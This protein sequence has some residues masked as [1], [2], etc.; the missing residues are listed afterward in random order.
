MT[1]LAAKSPAK[2]PSP[3]HRDR[4]WI[5]P[6]FG[7]LLGAV[8]WLEC[9]ALGVPRIP[10]EKPGYHLIPV[11]VVVGAILGR[12][13]AQ[14]F[15]LWAAAALAVVLALIA[16]TPVMRRPARALVRSDRI[17]ARPVQAVVVL[18]GGI[19]TDGHLRS[20]SLDRALSGISLIRRGVA[21]TLIVSR[22]HLGPPGRAVTSDA[23]HQ[24][25]VSLLERPIRLLIV[26]SVFSTRDEAVRIRALA[27]TLDITKVAV[28]TSPMHTYRACATF[29]KVGFTV[30]CVPS[31]SRDVPL[32]TLRI[33][34]DRVRAF[35]I[36]LYEVAGLAKYRASGWV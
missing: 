11:A 23:D 5:D 20:Q 27:R 19:T 9:I 22:E 24:R 25:I 28:V 29:E 4:R 33:T 18:S 12:T 30:T 1:D 26:D 14:R 16:F 36:W 7:A 8:L 10:F 21:G 6:S 15:L 3:S 2:G 35:Q 32:G 13:H 34:A 17:D 31:E